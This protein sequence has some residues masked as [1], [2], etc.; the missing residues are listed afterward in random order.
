MKTQTAREPT[1]EAK[2]GLGELSEDLLMKIHH[3]VNPYIRANEIQIGKKRILGK[4]GDNTL[5]RLGY[6]SFGASFQNGEYECTVVL[7]TQGKL[8]EVKD[9]RELY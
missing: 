5:I 9:V 4:E 2:E 1:K 6:K 7:N 3:Q 8:V